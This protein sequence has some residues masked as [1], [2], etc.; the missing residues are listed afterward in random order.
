MAKKKKF[1]QND[2]NLAIAYYRYSSHA[3][4]DAS[5][6]QQRQAAQTYAAS[7]GYTIVKEYED[8][9][10]SGRTDNRPQ[11]Q[12]MLYEIKKLKPA[13]LILWK[14]DRLGRDRITLILAKREIRGVGCNIHLVAETTPDDT[15]EGRMLEGMLEAVAE[16]ESD[17][18]AENIMRGVRYN[19]QNALHNGHKILGYAKGADKK[20]I[21][22]PEKSPVVQRIF[23]DYAS[24]KSLQQIANELN[25]Q[26]ITTAR[27]GKFTV[28]GLRSV[29]HNDAY[30][31]IFRYSDI[32]VEDGMPVLIT[33]ELFDQ[34]QA[35]FAE[36]KRKGAQVANGLN[37]DNSPRYWLTGKLFCGECGN[38]M[39][40]V[41]GTSKT[42]AKHYYYYCS[43]Q[44]K[45]Q[46]NKKHVKKYIIEELVTKLLSGIISDSENLASL[47]VETADYYKQYHADTGY[48]EGL[49]SQKKQTEK[50]LANILKAIEQGIFSET[51]QT[52]LLELEERNKALAETIETE[53]I[54]RQ[55]VQ[56]DHS[57]QS[58]YDQYL[59]A[60]FENPETRDYI[61]EYFVDKIYLYDDRLVITGCYTKD[62]HEITWAELNGEMQSPEFDDCVFSSTK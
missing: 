61:L 3:Q 38:S 22:D 34:V 39:Q 24:G 33:Q 26:G 2:N 56:D 36:N 54:K 46:C 28:N 58:Y 12:Q 16:Y 52:R 43:G 11:Y 9:A 18:I 37:E 7:K 41:S 55:L 60:D 5:I 45:H 50:G 35:R 62:K 21:V 20:Y 13:V 17:K 23:A 10:Q 6:E 53:K 47:A 48:L 42:S 40:G 1:I 57:I 59:H 19:A 8:H 29:L 14:T 31:G 15:S 30:L 32:V 49:E 4:N 44:R 51:T 25:Q 27:D